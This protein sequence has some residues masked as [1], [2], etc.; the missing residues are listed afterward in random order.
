MKRTLDIRKTLPGDAKERPERETTSPSINILL[1]E[2][3]HGAAHDLPENVHT[4]DVDGDLQQGHEESAVHCP[5]AETVNDVF[6]STPEEAISERAAGFMGPDT[7]VL[8]RH[9]P[10][11]EPI[12][13]YWQ[14]LAWYA[15]WQGI[16][17][18]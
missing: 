18:G 1:M 5:I 7:S 16:A 6:H 12:A 8:V 13:L 10:L 2:Q 3:Y 15:A 11:G 17:G 14:F 9:L 4:H